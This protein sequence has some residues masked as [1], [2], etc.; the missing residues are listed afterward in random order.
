[1]FHISFITHILCL[2]IWISIEYTTEIS[3]IKIMGV[4]M[5]MFSCLFCINPSHICQVTFY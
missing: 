3:R 5:T 4:S 2:I 1:M